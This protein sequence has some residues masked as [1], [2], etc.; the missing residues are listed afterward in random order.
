VLG[1]VGLPIDDAA[2]A[3]EAPPEDLVPPGGRM[4]LVTLDGEPIAIGG[5]R[6]LDSP[7]AEI[8]SMYVAPSG[9]RHGIAR[10]MLSQLEGIAAEHD[11]RAVRLDTAKHLTA[12]IALYRAAGYREIPAY[13]S[14]PLAELWFERELG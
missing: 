2:L 11:C 6:D 13:A 14:G 7:V 12:A 1:P 5:I 10:R 9:R 8:K 4:L 3:A